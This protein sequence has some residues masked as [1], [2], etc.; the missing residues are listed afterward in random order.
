MRP[1]TTSISPEEARE[2]VRNAI[3]MGTMSYPGGGTEPPAHVPYETSTV[4]AARAR[5]ISTE[6]YLRLARIRKAHLRKLKAEKLQQLNQVP[7]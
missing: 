7:A 1:N 6:E 2:I 3:R 5:G 4:R